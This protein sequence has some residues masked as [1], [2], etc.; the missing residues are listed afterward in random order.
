MKSVVQSNLVT[1]QS[2]QLGGVC[3]TPGRTLPLERH[4][5]GS[6]TR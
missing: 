5:K 3:S 2:E 6:Q 4:D 1:V